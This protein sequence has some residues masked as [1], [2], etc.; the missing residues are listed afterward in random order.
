MNKSDDEG[1]EESDL[2]KEKNDGELEYSYTIKI[3]KERI[4]IVIGKEGETKRNLE[5]ELKIKINV[6]SK[7][8]DVTISSKDSLRI[9]MVKEIIKAIGRGF[10]PEISLH[11]IKQ[12]ALLDIINIMDYTKNKNHLPRLKGRIIGEKGKSRRAIENL[13]ETDISVY[14]KT[15]GIIGNAENVTIAKRAIES[16][17]GGSPHASVYKFLEKNRREMKKREFI[18]R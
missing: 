17:L 11:L 10:S 5:E 8:G 1:V 4:A 7:E 13:T 12:D 9:Y 3:P 15:V 18:Q 14:G 6:D 16:L 2:M